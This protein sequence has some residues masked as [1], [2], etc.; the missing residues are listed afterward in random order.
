MIFILAASYSYIEHDF[1]GLKS[2]CETNLADWERK[3][4]DFQLL[5]IQNSISS[6]LA[7]LSAEISSLGGEHADTKFI[8]G[9]M[10]GYKALAKTSETSFSESQKILKFEEATKK[11]CKKIDIERARASMIAFFLAIIVGIYGFWAGT[12]QPNKK[13]EDTSDA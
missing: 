4:L 13:A 3:R 2:E 12:K 10:N 6:S 8:K 5:A 1:D 7:V 11:D 9:Q